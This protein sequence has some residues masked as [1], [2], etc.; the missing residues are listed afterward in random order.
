[1][2][3]SVGAVFAAMPSRGNRMTATAEPDYHVVLPPLPTGSCV[4]NTVFLHGDVKARPFRVED[5]RDTLAHLELLP[6][7]VALGAFQMNHVWA[8]TFESAEATKKMLKHAEVQVKER[9]CLVVDPHNREVRLKLHWLL[10]NVHDDDVH[11]AFV[12]YGKVSDI[13]KERWRVQGVTDKGSSMRTVSLKLKP[14]LTIDDLPHQIRIAGIMAL[15]V[16]AG[17]APLCLRCNRTGHI[18]REC[19]VPRCSVCRRFGHEDSQCVRTYASIAG[20][21]KNEEIVN[22]LLMDEVDAE[23]ICSASG[24]TL[25]PPS[26]KDLAVT[27]EKHDLTQVASEAILTSGAPTPAKEAET[28]NDA[29]AGKQPSATTSQDDAC[30]MDTTETSKATAAAKRTHEESAGGEQ[31]LSTSSASE[32][33]VK[34]ATG[35]RPT[36]RPAPNLPPD[37]KVSGI[38]PT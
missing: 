16:V 30:L 19:R 33:P 23:E 38:P 4:L 5:F 27:T 20:P 21:P 24:P 22:E 26:K 8:V 31:K 29:S 18:R 7:V 15:V 36:F 13:Q 1:M 14:G 9:R 37:R 17:R 2:S 10:H 3:R 28:N 11:A 25:S 32:P 6:E 12:P 34:T 35:R